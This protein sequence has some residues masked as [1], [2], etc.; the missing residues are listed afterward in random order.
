M[1]VFGG[2]EI[3]ASPN[4]QSQLRAAL[5]AAKQQTSDLGVAVAALE[6]EADEISG[7]AGPITRQFVSTAVV[8]QP[9]YLAS[10]ATVDLADADSPATAGVIG[11]VFTAATAG[12]D[13]EI[14]LSGVV[15]A[16]DWT[17]VIGTASLTAGSVYFL[18]GTTGRLTTTPPSTGT[19]VR[20]GRALSA[21][22]FH[23]K[24]ERGILL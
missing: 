23:V 2:G 18:S 22:E 10:A 4:T 21:T 13:G 24:I 14:L 12:T 8:G 6:A 1:A 5:G 17:S 9:V 3:N 16:A 20:C 7:I 15:T 19:S 11:L